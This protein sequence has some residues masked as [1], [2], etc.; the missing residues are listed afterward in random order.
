MNDVHRLTTPVQAKLVKTIRLTFC[1]VRQYRDKY[2]WAWTQFPDGSGY[3]AQPDLSED[4]ASRYARRAE[5][6]GYATVDDFCFVHEFSHSFIAQE[7][8]GSASLVLWPLAHKRRP[9]FTAGEESI[10]LHFQHVINGRSHDDLME[11]V[12]EGIDWHGL[13]A[14]A[15]RL[16]ALADDPMRDPA[17]TAALR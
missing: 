3:G 2:L 14:K 11:A 5:R 9:V 10:V 1:E 7:L 13:R 16:L 17:A 12:D 15:L 6:L 4:G 8:W